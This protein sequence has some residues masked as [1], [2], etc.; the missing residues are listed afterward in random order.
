M[1]YLIFGFVIVNLLLIIQLMMV[2]I[3]FDCQMLS[4]IQTTIV[5]LVGL[6]L[7]VTENYKPEEVGLIMAD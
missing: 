6:N 1:N 7:W 5:I 2:H 4:M 3:K